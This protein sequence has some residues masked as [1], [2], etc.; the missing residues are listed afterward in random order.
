MPRIRAA[1]GS[2]AGRSGLELAVVR[3]KGLTTDLYLWFS[4]YVGVG[5]L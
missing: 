5:Y 4:E 2:V 3:A 1:G